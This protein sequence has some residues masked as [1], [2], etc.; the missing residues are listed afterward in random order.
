MMIKLA[1]IGSRTFSD[2]SILEENIKG[3]YDLSK[4]STII[5]GGDMGADTLAETFA[6]KYNIKIAIYRPNW[7]L[8]GNKAEYIRNRLMVVESDEILAFWNGNSP[9]TKSKIDFANSIEKKISVVS[10]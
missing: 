2:F 5:S 9:G 1:I 7:I 3:R 6:T 8:Y 10:V 4:I